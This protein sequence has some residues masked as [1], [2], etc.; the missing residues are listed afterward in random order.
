VRVQLN[1]SNILTCWKEKEIQDLYSRKGSDLLRR[2][3]SII[4]HPHRSVTEEN[5]VSARILKLRTMRRTWEG[6]GVRISWIRQAKAS[7]YTVKKYYKIPGLFLT[8]PSRDR[9]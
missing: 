8:K 2:V 4:P 9:D 1:F 5:F 3:H 6:K 7:L